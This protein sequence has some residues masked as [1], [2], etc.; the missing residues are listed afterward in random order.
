[1]SSLSLL[2]PGLVGRSSFASAIKGANFPALDRLFN[3]VVEITPAVPQFEQQ[4]IRLLG[5]QQKPGVSAS[6][7]Y[8][9]GKRHFAVDDATRYLLAS[10]VHLQADSGRLLMHG[11]DSLNIDFDEAQQYLNELSIIFDDGGMKVHA[12]SPDCWVLCLPEPPGARFSDLSAVIGQDIHDFMPDGDNAMA[13]RS[14][15]NEVQMQ[16]HLSPVNSKRQAKG[17]KVVN[18][19]WIGGVGDAVELN[20]TSWNSLCSDNA[21]VR[22]LASQA[23]INKLASVTAGDSVIDVD[24]DY[25]LGV[26][27]ELAESVA[28]EDLGHWY[29]VLQNFHDTVA[30]SVAD[31]LQQG[32]L[33]EVQIYPVNGHCYRVRSKR[34]LAGIID[35]F[36]KKRD[37]NDYVSKQK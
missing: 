21:M 5:G 22:T 14:V 35:G 2:V 12:V 28:R 26:F 33:K 24:N 37:F 18:S 23:G 7:A 15:I 3:S 11:Q 19:L 29:D 25:Q 36:R 17:L 6:L 10:P 8:L 9:L 4:L 34:G 30:Q 20:K 16:L 31:A 13:W 1:L 27:T 32:D